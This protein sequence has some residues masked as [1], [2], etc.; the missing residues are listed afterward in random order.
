MEAGMSM[1]KHE[2]L[3]LLRENANDRG[4]E[5]WKRMD[6]TNGKWSSY[7]IGLTQLK[8]LAKKIGKDHKLALDLWEEPNFEAKQIAILIEDP[9]EVTEKQVDQQI[10]DLEFW[11]LTHVYASTLFPKLPFIREKA[12]KWRTSKRDVERRCGYL[13]LSGFATADQTAPDEHFLPII[14]TIEKNLQNEE[15]FVRDAMNTS[16]FSI[17]SRS[18]KLHAA[19]LKAAKSIGKVEVDY[20]DNSCQPLDVIK[21]L[22]SDRIKMKLGLM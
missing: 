12:K 11:M 21:H 5:N 20:G 8:K 17:G 13:A 18:R 14:A 9:K 10:N 4:I 3:K 22:N 15:N 19:A 2:V 7:G 6:P 16:L 1:T